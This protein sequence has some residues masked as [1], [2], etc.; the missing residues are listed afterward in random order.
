M[1]IP[2]NASGGGTLSS[3][4]TIENQT[5]S[6]AVAGETPSTVSYESHEKLLKEK[7][8]RDE[9]IAEKD[10]IIEAFKKKDS[11][12]SEAKA[13]EQGDLQKIIEIRDKEKA[14][15][16]QKYNEL[17]SQIVSS[18]KL[19]AFLDQ[20]SGTVDE[21]YW[22]LIDLQAIPLD[23]SNGMPDLLAVQRAAKEFE[24]KYS[25]VVQTKGGSKMPNGAAKPPGQGLLYEDWLRLPLKEKRARQH[26]VKK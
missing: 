1:S 8:R 12:T 6:N 25:L 3:S 17:N 20:V 2:T 24:Q 23:P 21:Q 18:V 10:R 13:K 26:E 19:R 7:K 5:Q 15:I 16:E 4:G 11:E 22:S 14:E 9:Q